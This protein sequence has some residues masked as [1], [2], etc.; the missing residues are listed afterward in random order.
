MPQFSLTKESEAQAE[1][2][3]IVLRVGNMYIPYLALF[4][5]TILRFFSITRAV[6]NVI[7]EFVHYHP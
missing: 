5:G 3:S 4:A 7:E 1:L 6:A 2:G